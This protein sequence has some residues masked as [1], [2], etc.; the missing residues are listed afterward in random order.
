MIDFVLVRSSDCQFCVNTQMMRRASCWSDHYL[1]RAKLHFDLQKYIPKWLA[2]KWQLAVHHL[3]SGDMRVKYQEV[4]TE[5]L[6][7]ADDEVTTEGFWSS[8]ILS[9]SEEV[10]GYGGRVQPD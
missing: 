6:N 9:A 10:V 8:L 4:L 7:H 1:V 2:R 5:N 3:T